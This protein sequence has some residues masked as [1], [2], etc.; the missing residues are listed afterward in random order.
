MRL[1][2]GVVESFVNGDISMQRCGKRQ[3]RAAVYTARVCIVCM[4]LFAGSLSQL[5]REPARTVRRKM[6]KTGWS[7]CLGGL[8]SQDLALPLFTYAMAVAHAAMWNGIMSTGTVMVAGFVSG[9]LGRLARQ[10]W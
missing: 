6:S 7:G 5:M 2:S 8:F 1:H 4:L 9:K 3:V 10:A